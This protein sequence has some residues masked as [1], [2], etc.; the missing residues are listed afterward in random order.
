MQLPL[1]TLTPTGISAFQDSLL[2]SR[3]D[4]LSTPHAWALCDLGFPLPL[5]VLLI[6]SVLLGTRPLWPNLVV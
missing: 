3:P 2:M 4:A 6:T 5:G 1:E